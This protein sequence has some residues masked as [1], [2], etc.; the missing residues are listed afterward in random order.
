MKEG[1]RNEASLCEGFHEGYFEGGLIYW[2]PEDMLSKAQKWASFSVGA[3]PLGNMDGRFFLGAFLLEEFLWQIYKMPCRR[4][5]LSISA[6]LGNQE[7]VCSPGILR[8]KKKYILVPFFD[9]EA[10]KSL[11]LGAIWNF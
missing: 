3:P 11:S 2:E 8:E 10:T 5:S 6:L 4:V 1:S 7:G 9:T